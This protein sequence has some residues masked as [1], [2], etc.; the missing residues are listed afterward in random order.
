MDSNYSKVFSG[1]QFVAKKIIDQ[2][3][4]VGI[5]AVV[6][7]ETESARMAG[8]ASTM[9]GDIELYVHND[10]IEKAQKVIAELS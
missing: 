1:N 3:R 6:K 4:E 10:E 2:L 5:I 8:F 9:D 7:D